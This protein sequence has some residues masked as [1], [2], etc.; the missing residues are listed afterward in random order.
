MF[1]RVSGDSAAA[2]LLQK[3]SSADKATAR[4]GAVAG[5]LL[6]TRVRIDPS[7]S[8]VNL[9]FSWAGQGSAVQPTASS[10]SPAPSAPTPQLQQVKEPEAGKQPATS[11][12]AEEKAQGG[13]SERGAK[14]FTVD[15]V[16]KHNKKDDVWVIIDDEVLDVTKVRPPFFHE[17]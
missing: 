6:E 2:Y 8:K 3:A 10:S 4:L 1:G 7:Q 14:A 9:E 5:H 12:A 15:E 17:N 13:A 16:A 11:A